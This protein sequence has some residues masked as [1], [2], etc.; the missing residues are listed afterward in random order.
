MHIYI[1]ICMSE[2]GELLRK[3]WF[4][5]DRAARNHVK[6]CLFLCGAGGCC[7][8]HEWLHPWGILYVLQLFIVSS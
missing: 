2:V 5:A 4:R 1:Y 7:A 3:G 8:A 6:A